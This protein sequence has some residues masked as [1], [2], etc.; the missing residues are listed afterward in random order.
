MENKVI[1]ENRNSYT[2][3]PDI[4]KLNN[5]HIVVGFR[6]PDAREPLLYVP[7][8]AVLRRRMKRSE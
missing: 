3:F 7:A 4:E 1:C 2:A 8:M 6:I 5:G